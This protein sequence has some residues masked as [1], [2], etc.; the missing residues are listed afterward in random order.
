[1]QDISLGVGLAWET[2]GEGGR[3]GARKSQLSLSSS[4]A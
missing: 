1:M 4:P 2:L 3:G